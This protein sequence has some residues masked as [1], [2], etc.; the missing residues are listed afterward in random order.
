[1]NKRVWKRILG[2]SVIVGLIGGVLALASVGVVE[3]VLA[4][5]GILLF[6]FA[7]FALGIFFLWCFD[8]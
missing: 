3:F 8:I 5:L 4:A 2:V 7:I 1:M 6:V